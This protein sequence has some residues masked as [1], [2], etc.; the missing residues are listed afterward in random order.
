MPPSVI[1]QVKS[2]AQLFRKKNDRQEVE[3][4]SS[5]MG[6]IFTPPSELPR[7]F[8]KV[9]DEG[10]FPLGKFQQGHPFIFVGFPPAVFPPVGPVDGGPVFL[11]DGPVY[12]EGQFRVLA[13]EDV[14]EFQDPVAGEEGWVLGK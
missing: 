7:V 11:N 1:L 6:K 10:D 14:E 13:E 3:K 4:L 9:A 8:K 2:R 12:G 5:L